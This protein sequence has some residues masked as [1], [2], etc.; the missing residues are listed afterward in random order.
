MSGY[1]RKRTGQF[2]LDPQISAAIDE[3]CEATMDAGVR[4]LCITLH[5]GAVDYAHL[6]FFDD[7]DVLLERDPQPNGDWHEFAYVGGGE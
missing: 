6:F 3:L 5:R 2:A 7:D 4:T 1:R